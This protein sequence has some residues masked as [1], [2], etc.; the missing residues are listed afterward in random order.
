MDKVAQKKSWQER[1]GEYRGIAKPVYDILGKY[2]GFGAKATPNKMI[3]DVDHHTISFEIQE[4][5][6][7]LGY[8]KIEGK[9]PIVSRAMEDVSKDVANE[10]ILMQWEAD[11]KHYGGG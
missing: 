4:K 5:L 1:D 2:M 6:R 11:I 8:R 7:E 10:L 3:I 9:P